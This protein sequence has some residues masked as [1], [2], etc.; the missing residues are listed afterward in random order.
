MRSYT[1]KEHHIGSAVSEILKHKQTDIMI[2]YCKDISTPE[3]KPEVANF[4]E[5]KKNK[6]KLK[7]IKQ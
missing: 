5:F 4:E 7:I 6:P 1:V 3:L 2:Q